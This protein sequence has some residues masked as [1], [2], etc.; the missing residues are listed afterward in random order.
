[1]VAF[2]ATRHSVCASSSSILRVKDSG[3]LG[4]RGAVTPRPVPALRRGRIYMLRP[5][6]C[7]WYRKSR[8][9]KETSVLR[10]QASLILS[11]TSRCQRSLCV[12]SSCL[13]G[14][15]AEVWEVGGGPET[16]LVSSRYHA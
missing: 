10:S 16:A 4:R 2:P 1:M 13:E 6:K 3:F 14:L 8:S 9:G 11:P 5:Q 12:P 7:H 15:K